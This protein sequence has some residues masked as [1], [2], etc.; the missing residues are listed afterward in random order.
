MATILRRRHRS[1][2]G[3]RLA[4]SGNSVAADGPTAHA[5]LNAVRA[6]S[7]STRDAHMATLYE[8]GAVRDVRR[9]DH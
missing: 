2:D 5:E 6:L 8:H 7:T 4:E 1:A 3:K 9:R